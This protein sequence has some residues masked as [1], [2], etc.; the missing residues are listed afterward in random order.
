MIGKIQGRQIQTTF[1]ELEYILTNQQSLAKKMAWGSPKSGEE[2]VFRR[3]ENN[4][5]WQ[6]ALRASN[7]EKGKSKG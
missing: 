3:K 5:R 7:E 2:E 4:R 1:L 6:N